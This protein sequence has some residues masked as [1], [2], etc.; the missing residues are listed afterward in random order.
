M[1][2]RCVK[3]CQGVEHTALLVRRPGPVG[4]CIGTVVSPDYRF[5]PDRRN[6]GQP[7]SPSW[8]WKPTFHSRI[9]GSFVETLTWPL[10]TN[11]MRLVVPRLAHPSREYGRGGWATWQLPQQG[12]AVR[13]PPRLL[14]HQE[15]QVDLLLVLHGCIRSPNIKGSV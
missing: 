14:V 9:C 2:S 1:V 15:L 7:R 13:D 6:R 12:V 8:P 3:V 11:T 5:N 4:A 10:S